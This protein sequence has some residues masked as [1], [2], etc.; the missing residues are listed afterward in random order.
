MNGGLFECLD[1]TLGTKENP[2]YIR[3]DG[4]SDRDDNALKIPNILFWGSERVVDLSE[5]Y[6][7]NKYSTSR[8]AGLV[9]I[10]DRYK[11][12][13]TENTPIDEEIALD[14]EL[15]GKAFENLL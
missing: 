1:K 5:D 15:L 13:V 9:R 11:F 14:P 6:G 2:Q 4:F 3:I 8:V 10:F 12:T 7:E